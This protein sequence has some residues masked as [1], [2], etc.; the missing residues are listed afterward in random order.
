VSYIMRVYYTFIASLFLWPWSFMEFHGL[1]CIVDLRPLSL[2]TSL[3][4]R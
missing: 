1:F 3:F 2:L 4:C